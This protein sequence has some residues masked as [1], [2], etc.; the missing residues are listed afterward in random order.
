MLSIWPEQTFI[1]NTF[2][3]QKKLKATAHINYVNL[4]PY[5]VQNTY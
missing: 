4:T 1:T 2:P 3:L 5:L